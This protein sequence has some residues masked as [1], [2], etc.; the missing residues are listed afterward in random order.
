MI[1]FKN[2]SFEY[3]DGTG[4]IKDLNLNI[5]K[6][7]VILLCGESGCGKSTLIRMI[8]G[9]IPSYY[10]G[11]LKGTVTVNG[12]DTRNAQLH[13]LAKYVASV[14]QNPKTQ[15]Y[16]VDSTEEMVFS[17]ENRGVSRE[18]ME[19]RLNQTVEKLKMDNLL[20]RNLFKMSGGEKQ[21]VACACAD[22]SDADIIVL[23]EPSS[24]LDLHTIRELQEII[25][26]W[27]K[28]GKTVVIA[29]HRLYYV[30]PIADRVLININIHKSKL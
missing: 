28:E 7:E 29:E 1:D 11:E 20:G 4:I 15:F 19:E 26:V 23:D 10:K 18:K 21:K 25:E 22:T 6:G 9:L 2:V 8:N 14:F 27:K 24:N 12:L 17:L 30:L 13:E 5:K 3:E 16:N